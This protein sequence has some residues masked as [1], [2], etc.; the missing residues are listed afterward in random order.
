MTMMNCT[1][2]NFDTLIASK[3]L[4]PSGAAWLK[5]AVDPFH[6]KPLVLAG[7]PDLCGAASLVEMRRSALNIDHAAVVGAWDC[8][9]FSTPLPCDATV[10]KKTTI[11]STGIIYI[12]DGEDKHH[13]GWLT[14]VV[15]PAGTI[16]WNNTNGPE[17]AIAAGG[18]C[19]CLPLIDSV[20]DET[21]RPIAGGFEVVNSTPELYKGG[22]VTVGFQPSY[23]SSRTVAIMDNSG[24]INCNYMGHAAE[25]SSPPGKIDVAAL[26]PEAL[27]WPA[28]RG[29]YCPLRFGEQNLPLSDISNNLF[30]FDEVMFSSQ[31]YYGAK[32]GNTE[33]AWSKPPNFLQSF[34]FFSN[35][36]PETTLRLV[37]KTW[38]ERFPRTRGGKVSDYLTLSSPS[39]PHDAVA[40]KLYGQMIK[41][42][43]AGVPQ[44]MNPA[45]E[46][47]AKF[48]LTALRDVLRFAGPLLG[49]IP[50]AGPF[51]QTGANI[52]SVGANVAKK[53]V[54]Q[55]AKQKKTQKKKVK[56][57]PPI[58]TINRSNRK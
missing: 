55:V 10:Q 51:L 8:L 53:A 38:I 30:S 42:L 20:A 32:Y 48:A 57:P 46:Y 44:D 56:R 7:Y 33:P 13:V 21:I 1:T 31:N 34:A 45:G 54:S 40:L 41:Q 28:S 25:F 39:A 6:D 29:C 3:Q 43:P 27:T 58:Q 4:T 12:D 52:A 15:G 2:N 19:T 47:Y 5:A 23:L 24:T 50:T 17:G 35:L 14:I 26:I 22:T 9:V 16:L 49:M 37:S 11:G 18:I 36:S